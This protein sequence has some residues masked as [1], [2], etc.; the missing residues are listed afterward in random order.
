MLSMIEDDAVI[1]PM[2][3]AA[4]DRDPYIRAVAS[5]TLIRHGQLP[6]LD[7]IKEMLEGRFG[8]C[9]FGAD[10][11]VGV[12][13][14]RGRV[15]AALSPHANA[16]IF[17]LLLENPPQAEIYD[18]PPG[19]S[20]FP[21]ANNAKNGPFLEL[22]NASLFRELGKSL[23]QHPEA[24]KILLTAYDD[25][26]YNTIRREF[27]RNVF[28]FAGPTMLPMLY[29]ELKNKD[30]VVRSNAARAC[31]AI[32]QRD[33]IPHLLA[34][35]DMESGLARASIVCALGELKAREALPQMAALYVD[36]RNDEKHRRASGFLMAQAAAQFESHVENL[37][38]RRDI[39]TEWD[40]LK[41]QSRRR[42]IDPRRNEDLLEVRTILDAV[43]K[44][45]PESSQE[46]YRTL[47]GESDQDVRQEAARRLGEVPSERDQNMPVLR[48]LLADK[49]ETVR[50]AAAVSLLMLGETDVCKPIM[51]WLESPEKWQSDAIIRELVRVKDGRLL[52][53]ARTAIEKVADEDRMRSGSAGFIEQLLKQI[54][55]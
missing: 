45:G 20:P 38:H 31:G 49:Q 14:D 9:P 15:V 37:R 22:G 55:K 25:E 19:Q 40:E 41:Q 3:E 44:I 28:R 16:E 1:V 21:N 18:V 17:K 5:L 24:S 8:N 6:S 30:R 7:E 12:L 39:E 34:A 13:V 29:N 11:S 32:G 54:P 52:V 2:K 48:N 23:R 42:P 46:F 53:F 33:A 27:S 35:L 36:A 51:T 10:S 50:M 43:A 4:H 47:A 26:P